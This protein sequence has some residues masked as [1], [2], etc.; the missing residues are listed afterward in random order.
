M[1][2]VRV[3]TE[4]EAINISLDMWAF[5]KSTGEEKEDYLYDIENRYLSGC[6][7]CTF[8][9]HQDE[10]DKQLFAKRYYYRTGCKNCCLFS[11]KLCKFATHNSAFAK[12]DNADI[13]S[14]KKKKYA[15]IIYDAL[16]KRK[17]ELEAT[18]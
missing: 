7:L 10:T 18:V 9:I 13:Y 3:E 14:K 4:L 1:S 15:S 5:L 6:T 2:Y 11:A 16:L 12:W 17:N 8:H